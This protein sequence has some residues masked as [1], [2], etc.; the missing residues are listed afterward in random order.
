MKEAPLSVKTWVDFYEF[1]GRRDY[2]GVMLSA[3]K[4]L[5]VNPGMSKSDRAFVEFN[6][7][8]AAALMGSKEHVEKFWGARFGKHSPI[9]LE[10]F[11]LDAYL[12][13]KVF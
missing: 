1:M 6:G 11:L 12:M 2:A 10:K 8:T 13:E 7:A 9:E 4:L 3:E 5:A